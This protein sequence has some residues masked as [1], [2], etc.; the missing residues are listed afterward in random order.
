[1]GTPGGFPK[2]PSRYREGKQVRLCPTSACSIRHGQEAMVGNVTY[3]EGLYRNKEDFI[4]R[5]PSD[6]VGLVAKSLTGF[7]KEVIDTIPDQ[8]MFYYSDTDK[9]V[10]KM[11]AVSFRGHLYIQAASVLLNRDR[12]DKSQTTSQPYSFTRV[13]FGGNNFLYMELELANSWKQGLGYGLGGVGGAAIAQNAIKGKGVV[14]DFSKNQF[15]IFRSCK[16]FNEF[17]AERYPQGVQECEDRQ[18][19][20][21]LVRTAIEQIK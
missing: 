21:L 18:P 16:D 8:C 3:P 9:K 12:Q 1:M 11:F 15:N 2:P 13:L 7:K 19:D 14:W 10:K 6:R 4:T 17:I 5:V 20:L